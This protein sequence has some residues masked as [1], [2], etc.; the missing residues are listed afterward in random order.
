[1]V[2]NIL[3]VDEDRIAS[4]QKGNIEQ[5]L[6]YHVDC[7]EKIEQARQ[8]INNNDYQ[9]LM[10]EPSVRGAPLSPH[11]SRIDFIKEVREKNI[12]VI[13]SSTQR[14]EDLLKLWGLVEGSD[15]QGFLG[16]PYFTE[17][18]SSEL[19]KIVGQ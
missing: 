2:L 16:K 18:I 19:R 7:A 14:K 3:L 6:G 8:F 15:Y 13:I 11:A 12:P 1:M 17:D 5:N 10:I 4:I 9:A